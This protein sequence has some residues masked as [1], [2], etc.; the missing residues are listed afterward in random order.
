M[1]ITLRPVGRGNWKTLYLGSFADQQAAAKAYDDAAVLHFGKHAKLNFPEDGHVSAAAPYVRPD[2]VA[3]A[4]DSR[5]L[6][7]VPL[8]TKEVFGCGDRI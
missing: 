8:K 3:P 5:R 1:I 2:E 7:F 4:I 6:S